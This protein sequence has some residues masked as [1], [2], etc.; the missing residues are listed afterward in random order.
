MG[1]NLA[2]SLT[3]LGPRSREETIAAVIALTSLV[4][5][6]RLRAIKLKGKA[7]ERRR[8]EEEVR[9]LNAGLEERVATPN[10]RACAGLGPVSA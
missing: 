3:Q 4:L 8:A 5:W 7:E 2:G 1:S 9:A 10:F 6:D